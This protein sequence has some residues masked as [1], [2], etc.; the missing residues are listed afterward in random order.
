MAHP[1]GVVGRAASVDEPTGAMD[2]GDTG[3]EGVPVRPLR[4][5]P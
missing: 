3:E 2:P 5:Y 4:W 1:V